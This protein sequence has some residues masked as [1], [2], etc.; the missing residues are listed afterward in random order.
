MAKRIYPD[1]VRLHGHFSAYAPEKLDA[2]RHFIR[3]EAKFFL[4]YPMRFNEGDEQLP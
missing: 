1:L 3:P 4:V 2:G